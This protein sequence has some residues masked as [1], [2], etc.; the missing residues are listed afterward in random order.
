MN[1]AV[2]SDI[3]KA[4]IDVDLAVQGHLQPLYL[5]N[6]VLL[7]PQGQQGRVTFYSAGNTVL[8]VTQWHT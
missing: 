1:R 7:T 3:N 5:I 6:I 2:F 8:P 4:D